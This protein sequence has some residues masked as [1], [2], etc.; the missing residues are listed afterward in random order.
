MPHSRH[1]KTRHR[2]WSVVVAAAVG[3]LLSIAGWVWADD[4]RPDPARGVPQTTGAAS[5][6]PS[7][8]PSNSAAEPSQSSPPPGSGTA[9]GAGSGYRI[10]LSARVAITSSL[11]VVPITGSFPA[12]PGATLRVQL[13]HRSGSWASFPLPAVVDAAGR[14]TTYVELGRRGANRLRVVD[15]ASGL[16]SNTVTVRVR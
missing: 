16:T 5:A 15:P 13:Q 4:E 14:F 11:D 2:H 7:V 12:R 8:D 3:V 6:A 9:S 1:R 10:R